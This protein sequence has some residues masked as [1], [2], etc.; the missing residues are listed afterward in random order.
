MVVTARPPYDRTA[1]R[2][3]WA[4]LPAEVRDL[5]ADQAGSAVLRAEVAGGGFTRGFAGLLVLADGTELFVKAASEEERPVAHRSYR[6]EADVLQVLPAA[7]PAPRLRWIDEVGPWVVLGIEPVHGRM[8]G[9]PWTDGDVDRAVA[10]CEQ[11]ADALHPA[12][13]GLTLD[14]LAD[15]SEGDGAWLRWYADVAGGEVVSDLLSPWARRSLPE[16]QR[17]LSLSGAAVDGDTACHGDLR[18]DNMLLGPA[19]QVW[20]C[21]WNWLLLA[22]PWTDAV[23][24]LVTAYADGVDVDG[25]LARSSLLTGVDPEAVDAWLALLAAFMC[26]QAAAPVPDFA[27]PWLAAHRAHYGTSALRWLEHRRTG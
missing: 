2:P 11:L 17:L 6:T 26:G 21:D 8:P 13:P 23:G 1:V 22:A 27:S 15:E 10:T 24:L 16:L 3:A 25:A 18:A 12:P 5:V 20:V 9:L 7:V 4:E 19:G 14:R